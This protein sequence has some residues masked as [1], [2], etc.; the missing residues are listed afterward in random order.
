MARRYAKKQMERSSDGEHARS[1]IVARAAKMVRLSKGEKVTIYRCG[2]DGDDG[3]DGDHRKPD[4]CVNSRA[5]RVKKSRANTR[6]KL[7]R[8]HRDRIFALKRISRLSGRTTL[9]DFYRL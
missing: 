2:D 8:V 5:P 1:V 9:I 4:G 6:K 3:D 7:Y